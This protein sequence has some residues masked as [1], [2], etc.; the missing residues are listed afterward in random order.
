MAANGNPLISLGSLNR[1]RGSV[2][3]P[4]LPSLNVTASY[5]GRSGIGLSLEGDSTGMIPAM[6][7][8]VTSPEPYMMVNV[9]IALL[10]TQTLAAQ[11]KTQLELN[12]LIGPFTVIPDASVHP[13]YG[14]DNAAIQSVREMSFAGEDPVWMVTLRGTYYT[15][16]TLWNLV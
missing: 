7:G 10:R 3:I 16:S 6:T 12:S 4:N 13:N 9:T 14:V 2:V 1:L 15:N 11:Y 8:A 5:L